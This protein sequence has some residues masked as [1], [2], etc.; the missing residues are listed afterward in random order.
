MARPA[1][2]GQ[3]LTPLAGGYLFETLGASATL[4]LLCA[5]A[6]LNVALVLLL[7]KR[8]PSTPPAAV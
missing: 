6:L 3:A 5:L 1:L 8:L 7:K 4:W 2:I